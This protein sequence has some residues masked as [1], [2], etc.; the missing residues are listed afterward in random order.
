M[1]FH[2]IAHQAVYRAAHGG[3]L[4]QHGGTVLAVGNGALQSFR[5]AADA[6]QAVD[7]AFFVLRVMGHGFSLNTGG[8]IEKIGRFGKRC[9]G[10]AQGRLNMFIIGQRR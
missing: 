7:G 5:L 3:N 8:S 6:A 4:L 9:T 2:H 1:A 10:K